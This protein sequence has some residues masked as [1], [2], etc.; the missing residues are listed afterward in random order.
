MPTA[1][2]YFDSQRKPS[3]NLLVC[4]PMLFT[5][6]IAYTQNRE[7]LFTYHG[8]EDYPYFYG[9]A[10][11][12]DQDYFSRDRINNCDSKW[13]WTL[14]AN[15]WM[16]DSWSVPMPVGWKQVG[17]ARF[18]EYYCELVFRLYEHETE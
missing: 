6:V 16:Q 18:Q 1:M 2:A 10:V 12:R 9:S 4:N 14:D 13:I 5:S 15:R 7:G 8:D 11:M 3:E 17:E